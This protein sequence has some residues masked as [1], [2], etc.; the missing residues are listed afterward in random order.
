MLFLAQ[1]ET[2]KDKAF[3]DPVGIL[4]D[5]IKD[6]TAGF[7]A[8]LPN[9]VVAIVIILLTWII[10]KLFVKFGGKIISKF[11]WRTSLQELVIILGKAGIWILGFTIAA[12]ILFPGLSPA[13]ALGTAGLASVAI[14]FAFKDIFQNFFAG[15][16]LM[17][18]FPFEPGDFI[19]CQDVKGKVIETELRMTTIRSTSG[20][21]LVVPNSFLIENPI[22]V[23]TDQKLRRME[24]ATGVAYDEDVPAAVKV[25]E[26]ALENCSSIDK[27]KPRDILVSGFG[28]S[29]IDIDVLYWTKSTPLDM[30]KSRSEVIIA[31]KGALDE[32]GIE[33]PFPYRT[34]TFAE[35]L[36]IVNESES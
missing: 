21:L 36:K 29:S 12:I 1:T 11:H 33:I 17:W 32:A 30:R 25:I 34:M 16:L 2:E 6:I 27:D 5:S 19:E 4:M 24:I 7:I 35:P 13:K 20:E 18:K 22:D 14:G 9:I 10:A 31:I 23:L 8:Q 15:I 28:A 26:K 3:T